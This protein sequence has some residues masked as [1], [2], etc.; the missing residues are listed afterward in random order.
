[1]P[2]SV[3]SSIPAA[4][5]S[6]APSAA[7]APGTGM[8][9]PTGA[10]GPPPGTALPSGYAQGLP[11]G[12]TRVPNGRMQKVTAIGGSVLAVILAVTLTYAFTRPDD[13]DS[14]ARGG[15]PVGGAPTT[16]APRSSGAGPSTAPTTGGGAAPG[17]TGTTTASGGGQPRLLFQDRRFII[18]S[19]SW[20]QGTHVDLDGA[21]AQPNAEIGDTNGY[22]IEYQDWSGG[23]MRFLTT[24]G[25]A[26]GTTY[27]ACRTGVGADALPGEIYGDD[28]GKNTYIDK[29]TV[30]CTMTADGDLAML[31]ITEV[32]PAGDMMTAPMPSYST[33]LT[34]WKMPDEPA[35]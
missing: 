24:F 10:D 13:K 22:E 8:F 7:Y 35:P 19:P 1:M 20:N 32:T 33:L 2:S 3:P 9:G 25:K 34:V 18:R 31:K 30:L 16:S 15:S 4:A 27:E 5:S 11:A 17:T 21:K 23:S 26:E 12:R 6:A 29:G 28:L 14:G